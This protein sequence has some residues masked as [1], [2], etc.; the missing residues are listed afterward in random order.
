MNIERCDGCGTESPTVDHYWPG[1]SWFEITVQDRS[2]NNAYIKTKQKYLLCRDCMGATAPEPL[3]RLPWLQRLLKA[4]LGN[5]H[6]T[7][8]RSEVNNIERVKEK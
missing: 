5:C 7:R 8:L 6:N 4:M 1:N 3:P 2:Q